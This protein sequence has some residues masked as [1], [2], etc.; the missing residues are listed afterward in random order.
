MVHQDSLRCLLDDAQAR[1]IDRRTFMRRGTALGLSGKALASILLAAGVVVPQIDGV[2]SATENRLAFGYSIEA[3]SLDPQATTVAVSS[4]VINRIFGALFYRDLDL[5]YKGY[6]AES[7]EISDN[8]SEIVFTLRPGITYSNGAEFDAHSVKF[9]MD[10]MASEGSRSPNYEMAL[11]IKTE[12]I[13]SHK[14]KFTFEKPNA[15]FFNA[16]AG[17][18]GGIMHP[19]ATDAA[20]DQVG[21]EPVGTDAYTLKEWVTGSAISLQAH[22]EY[23][24]PEE[25][26]ENKGAPKIEEIVYRV[27]PDAFAQVASLET[28]EIDVLDLSATDLPR[29][30]N[31]PDFEIFSSQ[32]SAIRYL[33]MNVTRPALSDVRVRK[34]IASAIDR[35]ELVET[36]Y[37][38]G[39]AEAC[40]TPLPP[41]IPG[42]S[43]SLKD[44]VLPFD[45]DAAAAFLDDAGWIEGSNGIREKDGEPLQLTLL[46]NT[47]TLS[48]QTAT[49]LQAQLLRAGIGIE[50]QAMEHAAVYEYT[51]KG[52]HD[53]HYGQWGWSDPDALYLFYH[54]SRMSTLNHMHYSNPDLDA[55]LEEG[56]QTMDQE[57]RAEVYRKAQ[58]IM[59]E[60]LP[61]IALVMP[62]GKTAVNTRV[63]D[64]KIFPTG[65]L[66]LNDAHID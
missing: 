17:A 45:L 56:R 38:G 53:L 18:Y 19:D 59:L 9:T 37:E 35:D 20:G 61:S 66:L 14:I 58:E 33:G 2:V 42:F 21:R 5:T 40:G 25:Y 34:A 7:W 3:D 15:A 64:A 51:V 55:L 13:D 57:D 6:L 23:S 11:E 54:S 28:G 27:I 48:A 47:T 36:L 32:E 30:E 63:K 41:S 22:Q 65:G 1:R 39:L 49:L 24:T 46:V 50:I 4:Y 60:D 52:E 31:N 43:E 8:N 62:I 26:Y 10:R 16:F 12:V 29:F 44:H